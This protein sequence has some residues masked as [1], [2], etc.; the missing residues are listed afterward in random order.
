MVTVCGKV[1]SGIGRVRKRW[2]QAQLSRYDGDLQLLQ[3]NDGN[4]DC[5]KFSSQEPAC[6]FHRKS[7]LPTV[8]PVSCS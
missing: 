4:Q 5:S 3:K 7:I 2:S 6:S 8:L 1:E